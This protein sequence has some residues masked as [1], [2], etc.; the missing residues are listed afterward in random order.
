VAVLYDPKDHS[1]VEPDQQPVST[2]ETAIDAITSAR[3]ENR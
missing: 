2:A 1:G 3:P